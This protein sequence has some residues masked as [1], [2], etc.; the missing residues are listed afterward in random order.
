[1]FRCD[2]VARFTRCK[3]YVSLV[4]LRVYVM[5]R[6]YFEADIGTAIRTHA[7]HPMVVHRPYGASRALTIVMRSLYIGEES[8]HGKLSS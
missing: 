2:R 1:M 7:N 5:V 6:C 4:F 8:C 3:R